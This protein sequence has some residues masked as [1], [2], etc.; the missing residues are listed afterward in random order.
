MVK[1]CSQRCSQCHRTLEPDQMFALVL[2]A[3]CQ[4]QVDAEFSEPFSGLYTICP[5]LMMLRRLQAGSFD[6]R[7]YNVGPT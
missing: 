1:R 4:V 7:S 2:Q 5:G 3:L 6:G